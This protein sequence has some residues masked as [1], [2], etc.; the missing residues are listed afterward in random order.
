[1]GGVRVDV[2]GDGDLER[3]VVVIGGVVWFDHWLM[4]PICGGGL[5]DPLSSL[6][7]LHS[8]DLSFSRSIVPSVY[9]YTSK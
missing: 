7:M 8:L 5:Q 3:E 2:D 9:Y 4:T 1:M 6:R